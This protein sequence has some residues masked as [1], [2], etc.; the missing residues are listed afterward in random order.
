MDM[1]GPDP[2]CQDNKV[3]RQDSSART[4]VRL[5]GIPGAA[6]VMESYIVKT[7]KVTS[8]VNRTSYFAYLVRVE[9]LIKRISC[10][11]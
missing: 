3:W 5:F 9:N 2:I 4:Y 10:F 11:A 8:I 1:N 6:R 7:L